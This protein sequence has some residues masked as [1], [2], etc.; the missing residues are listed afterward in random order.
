MFF[1]LGEESKIDLRREKFE[2][3]KNM[4]NA[5]HYSKEVQ[6]VIARQ[7]IVTV[8]IVKKERSCPQVC[9]N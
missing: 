7:T 9:K 6:I 3:L 2:N 8:S 1:F 5:L 4:I